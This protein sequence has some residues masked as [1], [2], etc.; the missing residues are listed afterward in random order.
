MAVVCSGRGWSWSPSQRPPRSWRRVRR[1]R[2]M[3]AATTATAIPA[4]M[5]TMMAIGAIEATTAIGIATGI[6]I[7]TATA[8]GTMTTI[9]GT[10]TGAAAIATATMSNASAGNWGWTG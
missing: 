7:D 9:T 5:T 6:A 8:I 2:D 1:G 10:A 3:A 4:G